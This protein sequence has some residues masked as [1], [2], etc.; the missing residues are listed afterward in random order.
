MTGSID[1]H[2]RGKYLNDGEDTSQFNAVELFAGAG[3]LMLGAAL[4]GC[5]T[6]LAA[7]VDSSC[8]ETLIANQNFFGSE[9]TDHLESDCRDISYENLSEDIHLLLGGPPCQPFS[10][11]GNHKAKADE[12][13]MFPEAIRA[14]KCIKPKVFLLENVKGLS[15]S[16]FSDYFEYLQLQMRHPQ[17]SPLDDENWLDHLSRLQNHHTG[18]MDSSEDYRVISRVLNAADYGVPQKRERVFFI[19]IRA[20]LSVNW[21]FP[22][23]THS[24]NALIASQA[25]KDGYFDGHNIRSTEA[26]LSNRF[27]SKLN[28]AVRSLEVEGTKLPWVTVRDALVGLPPPAV[29]END[30]AEF[31]GHL[32]KTGARSYPG[33]TGSPLDE[34]AKTIK[35]GVHGVPGG[36][37]MIRYAEGSVRYLTVRETARI[38]TFPD[39]YAFSGSWGSAMKQ[40]GNAVPV[41]MSSVLIRSILKSLPPEQGSNS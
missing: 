15:R 10:L 16:N 23:P 25:H 27:Q 26:V 29:D 6:V 20:D 38:Q 8:R 36:E 22:E 35:A 30:V 2:G 7:E 24:L 34:P 17:L 28:K 21:R 13:N 39:D 40:L 18:H 3:G 9:F 31:Q 32:L 37:N 12:R 1:L 4:S 41:D 14:I 11:G 33:H 19:G 5:R